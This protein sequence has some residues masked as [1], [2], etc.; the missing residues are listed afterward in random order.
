MNTIKNKINYI[1]IVIAWCVAWILFID[2]FAAF[3]ILI[4]PA[5]VTLLLLTILLS[6]KWKTLAIVS[7]A[8]VVALILLFIATW[9][10][11]FPLTIIS[12]YYINIAILNKSETAKYR[13]I[14]CIKTI[15]IPKPLRQFNFRRDSIEGEAIFCDIG[16]GENLIVTLSF[17]H[18]SYGVKTLRNLPWLA[19]GFDIGDRKD[20]PHFIEGQFEL[21]GDLI[22]I[23]ISFSDINNPQSITRVCVDGVINCSKFDFSVKRVWVEMTQDNYKSFGIHNKIQWLYSMDSAGIPIY[24]KIFAK[25]GYPDVRNPFDTHVN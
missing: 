4:I 21:T 9:A 11:S 25:I 8:S 19:A 22:P 20:W 10:I 24:K 5:W 13:G 14:V 7:W 18:D 2:V 17:P 12:N 16:S 23:L 15:N 6:K 3:S 1:L